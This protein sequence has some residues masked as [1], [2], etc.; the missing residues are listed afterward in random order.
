[1]IGVVLVLSAI[2]VMFTRKAKGA[3]GPSWYTEYNVLTG[4]SARSYGRLS[5][6]VTRIAAGGMA[7]VYRAYFY[8]GLNIG[9]QSVL[10]DLAAVG[11]DDH[12]KQELDPRF[13]AR[14]TLVVSGCLA[15]KGG[16]SLA[17]VPNGARV[18]DVCAR[19]VRAD[20]KEFRARV[21]L[22]TPREREY[23]RHGG[24]LQFVLRRLLG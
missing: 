5:Y 17:A 23:V 1:M 6:Y 7:R 22:D 24:I 15:E 2:A 3:G 9:K 18:A 10:A 13:V 11:A 16:E 8:E 20:A 12:G 19:K 4:L 21:R 14:A